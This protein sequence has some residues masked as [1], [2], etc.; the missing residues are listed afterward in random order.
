MPWYDDAYEIDDYDEFAGPVGDDDTEFGDAVGD[1]SDE[2][3][4]FRKNIFAG[5]S[6]KKLARLS[7]SGLRRG[8]MSRR[9]MS[10]IYNLARRQAAACKRQS[11]A[12]K[13]AGFGPP[14]GPN[15]GSYGMPFGLGSAT[16]AQSASATI[17]NTNNRGV[18][19]R[20][21]RLIIDGIA[22]D[23]SAAVMGI[24]N[25][26]VTAITIGDFPILTGGN[27]PVGVFSQGNFSPISYNQ[28]LYPGTQMSVTITAGTTLPAT[29]Q[30]TIAAE[31]SQM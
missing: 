21:K 15:T 11:F 5:R 24:A 8:R 29:I 12:W 4:A 1:D 19:L 27:V 25:A 17:Q 14:T 18:P 23:E 16:I 9:N 7:R 3:G 28:L 6:W 22:A 13:G 31:V 30:I 2:M 26:V 20:I 10:S